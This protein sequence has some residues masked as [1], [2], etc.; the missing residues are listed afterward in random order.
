MTKHTVA[1]CGA[2]GGIPAGFG[3]DTVLEDEEHFDAHIHGVERGG[4]QG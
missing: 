2:A 3:A 1:T 4:E